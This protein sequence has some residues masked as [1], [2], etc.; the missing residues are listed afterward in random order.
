MILTELPQDIILFICILLHPQDLLELIKTCRVLHAFG[1]SDYVWHHIQHDLPLEFSQC[2]GGGMNSLSGAEVRDRVVSALRLDKNWRQKASRLH[3]ITKV[4]APKHAKLLALQALGRKWMVTMSR[5]PEFSIRLTIWRMDETY[6]GVLQPY[7]VASVDLSDG[8]RFTASL[9]E[10]GDSAIISTLGAT[11]TAQGKLA[12]HHI[13]L[14]ALE[15]D[16]DGF[17]PYIINEW[18]FENPQVFYLTEIF[19]TIVAAVSLLRVSQ[20]QQDHQ[21]LLFNT[22]TNVKILLDVPELAEFDSGRL[23]IKIYTPYIVIAG[24]RERGNHPFPQHQQLDVR[25]RELPSSIFEDVPLSTASRPIESTTLTTWASIVADYQTQNLPSN[26]DINISLEP[27]SSGAT[28]HSFTVFACHSPP[29]QAGRGAVEVYR[30]PINTSWRNAKFADWQPIHTFSTPP[31]VSLEPTCVGQ[32]GCRAVWL[33]HQWNTDDYRLMKASLPAT[34]E[35]PPLVMPLEAQQFSLP[36]LPHTICSLTFE[37]STGRVWV[38][39]HTGE[40]YILEF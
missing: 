28:L 35:M 1:S 3:R 29:S 18:E 2:Q 5:A 6:D 32:N 19:G 25:V 15:K 30:F 27:V 4:I 31:N 34:G 22:K 13:N 8:F 17:S 11:R 10:G 24:V 14:K 23:Y 36:F 16:E 12:I 33:E 9:Q 39:V 7:A 37:E 26:L 40:I 21:I 38:A 20:S